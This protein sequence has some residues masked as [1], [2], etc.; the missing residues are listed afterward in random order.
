LAELVGEMGGSTTEDVNQVREGIDLVVLAG[1]GR[2]IEDGRR[3]DAA[4]TPQERP[5]ATFMQR[6]S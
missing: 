5:V 6:F 1:A 4:V 3:P 2:G